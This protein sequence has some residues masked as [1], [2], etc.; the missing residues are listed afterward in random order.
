MRSGSPRVEEEIDHH[1]YFDYPNN[2]GGF[3]VCS[4]ALLKGLGHV[5]MQHGKVIAYVS[6]Q[7]KTHEMNYSIHDLVLV[8]V[9]FALKIWHHYIYGEI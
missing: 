6:C 8:T 3:I 5:L 2:I 1:S 7:L 4:D 9:V